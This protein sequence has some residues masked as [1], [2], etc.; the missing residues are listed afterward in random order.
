M[1]FCLGCLFLCYCSIN[2]LILLNI[3][4]RDTELRV[5]RLEPKTQNLFVLIKQKKVKGRVFEWE[6]IETI[7]WKVEMLVQ[8]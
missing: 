1:S 6:E 3:N 5:L 4:V 2:I 7:W 8:C